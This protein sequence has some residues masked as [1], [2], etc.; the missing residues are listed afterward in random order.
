MQSTTVR[1]RTV[2]LD[3]DETLVL[4]HG[5]AIV[6]VEHLRGQQHAVTIQVDTNER[7]FRNEDD[8][9]MVYVEEE[10]A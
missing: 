9:L 1:F 6:G 7:V 2:T 3:P 10:D 4:D 8:K 5:E